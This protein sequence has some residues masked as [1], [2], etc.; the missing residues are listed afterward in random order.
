[1]KKPA[2][3]GQYIEMGVAASCSPA[4]LPGLS[5][6]SCFSPLHVAPVRARLSAVGSDPSWLRLPPRASSL[7]SSCKLHKSGAD[8]G[9]LTDVAVLLLWRRLVF[10]G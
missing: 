3:L 2:A 4:P 1:M 6:G 8:L 7:V 9:L 10:T 5:S